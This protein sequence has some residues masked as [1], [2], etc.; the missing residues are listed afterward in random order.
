MSTRSGKIATIGTISVLAVTLLALCMTSLYLEDSEHLD[1]SAMS[2]DYDDVDSELG[3]MY[4]HASPAMFIGAS[5]FI[6]A[7]GILL[8]YLIRKEGV[9]NDGIY[10]RS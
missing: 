2:P 3:G 8:A 10:N 1:D 7:I 5:V 9:P 4:Q 6:I